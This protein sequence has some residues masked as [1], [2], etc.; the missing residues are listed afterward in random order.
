MA[1]AP[2]HPRPVRGPGKHAL[3]RRRATGRRGVHGGGPQPKG[4]VHCGRPGGLAARSLAAA[5]LKQ[6]RLWPQ[7][8]TNTAGE[9]G[10]LA[11][12]GSWGG[13]G[14]GS[15][16]R[17]SA[18]AGGLS[19]W[20]RGRCRQSAR[21]RGRQAPQCTRVQVRPASATT[22]AALRRRPLGRGRA[23]SYLYIQI[24]MP[25]IGRK[26]GRRQRGAGGRDRWSGGG[27][28][29]QEKGYAARVVPIRVYRGTG[30][31]AL[32]TLR[33]CDVATLRRCD[34]ATLRRRDDADRAS[35]AAGGS[36]EAPFSAAP[37]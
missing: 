5:L 13:A 4:P 3:A 32:Q 35:R 15:T 24:H 11:R 20:G 10:R 25:R 21:G 18:S 27:G 29:A 28:G 17:A 26:G 22:R 33:R 36:L 19:R 8:Q 2:P 9:V 34:C 16:A 6:S 1:V 7:R 31:R 14:A 12:P 37:A 30:C 23:R